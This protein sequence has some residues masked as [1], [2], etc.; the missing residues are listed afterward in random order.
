MESLEKKMPDKNDFSESR[1]S[2]LWSEIQDK[3]YSFSLA[4]FL[5]D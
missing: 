4:S 2:L 5:K 1:D 3:S